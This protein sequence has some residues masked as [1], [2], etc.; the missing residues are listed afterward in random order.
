MEQK[1]IKGNGKISK[2]LVLSGYSFS[3]SHVTILEKNRNR[4]NKNKQM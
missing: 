2:I 3:E 4:N 1:L